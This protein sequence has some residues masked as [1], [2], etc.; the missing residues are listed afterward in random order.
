MRS[1]LM[2]DM[3]LDVTGKVLHRKEKQIIEHGD[4]DVLIIDLNDIAKLFEYNNDEYLIPIS[5]MN[6]I[7][8][9]SNCVILEVLLNDSRILRDYIYSLKD[10]EY[11]RSTLIEGY[12]ILGM[13]LIHDLVDNR[14]KE[15]AAF[16]H[17]HILKNER[18]L[19]IPYLN[20]LWMER[21]NSSLSAN[22]IYDQEHAVRMMFTVFR[23]IIDLVDEFIQNHPW[24]IYTTEVKE[25]TL[26]IK[27]GMDYRI[28]FY[29][30]NHGR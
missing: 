21:F 3:F 8:H 13:Q 5:Q 11:I 17:N 26:Y 28:Q 14:L 10:V 19:L 22:I 25:K 9:S 1:G 27:R 15:S 23:P 2:T 30:N 24:N 7:N 29:Y 18:Q 12:P 4:A 16:Q 20:P 6:V